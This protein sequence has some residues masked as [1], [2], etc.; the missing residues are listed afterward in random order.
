MTPPSRPPD[1]APVDL[2]FLLLSPAASPTAHL[3]AMGQFRVVRRYQGF[4]RPD[5]A[6][7]VAERAYA[8]VYLESIALSNLILRIYDVSG[9]TDRPQILMELKNAQRRYRVALLDLA[10]VYRSITDDVNFFGQPFLF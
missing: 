2:V 3:Q 7:R 1:G 10:A 9:G 4:N 5:L 6:R 8:A